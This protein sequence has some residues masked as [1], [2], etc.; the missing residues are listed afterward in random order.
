MR[1]TSRMGTAVIALTF[2]GALPA[3]SLD[4]RIRHALDALVTSYPQAL[5]SQDGNAVHWRDGTVMT[6]SDGASEKPFH[7]R[8]D[9]SS[10][11]DQFHD[12]YPHGRLPGPPAVDVDPG[13]YRNVAF[14]TKMYGDCRKGEVS[15]RLVPVV[16][17]P[18]S[19]GKRIQIT[20]VSGVNEHLAAVSEEIESLP[21][22]IRR[23]AYPSAGTYNCRP[24]ADT[25]LPSAHGFG[26]AIDL[27]IGVSDY[28]Y[29]QSHNGSINYRNR[30]PDE[31]VAIFERHGFIWGG[32][33]YHFDTMHFEYR[34]ELL[35]IDN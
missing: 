11:V 35:A 24:V 22:K 23:A 19:W 31:I 30:M 14:F 8:I 29:W 18:K 7:D 15:A 3:L 32:K 6:A 17:L 5:V 12:P 33:W 34:P 25:G 28:W 1:G 21:E 4:D 16:W 9:H 27:N 20:S 13:R 10:L 26:I 2:V